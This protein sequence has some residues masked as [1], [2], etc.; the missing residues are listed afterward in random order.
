MVRRLF[1]RDNDDSQL[2]EQS[3]ADSNTTCNDSTGQSRQSTDYNI[4]LSDT[5]F[6]APPAYDT[7][8]IHL[9]PPNYEVPLIPQNNNNFL[10][11]DE[12][13]K[14]STLE[15][16]ENGRNDMTAYEGLEVASSREDVR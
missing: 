6:P 16:E 9:N 13:P 3:A 1:H 5:S 8:S 15:C 7:I 12:P 4:D 14:Y 10:D 11:S 2:N